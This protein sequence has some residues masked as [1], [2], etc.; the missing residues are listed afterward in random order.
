MTHRSSPAF[1]RLSI[2]TAV[3][4]YLLI[5]WGGV[6]RVSGSGLGCGTTNDWPLCHGQLLPP[7]QQDAVIEFTHRWL[8]AMST[9]LVAT[10]AVVSLVRWLRIRGDS[11]AAA[12]IE[13][14]RRTAQISG[15][16]V[17]LFMVQIVLGAITVKLQLPGYV[18]AVHLANAEFLLGSL[19][20]LAVRAHFEG[21]ERATT[22]SRSPAMAAVIAA[23]I[24]TYAL[25]ITGS[26]VV[27]SS[28]SDACSAWP[29]CGNG[30]QLS[31]TQLA[32][33]NLFHRFIAGLVIVAIGIAVMRVARVHHQ[34][35]GIR[36]VGVVATVLLLAQVIAGAVVVK[37][38]LPAAARGIHLALASA[39]WASVVLLAV[40]VRTAPLDEA[41]E[42][43]RGTTDTGSSLSPVQ[44]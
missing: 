1:R 22:P 29:L 33:V 34:C 37:A 42:H 25:V 31:T 13:Q 6:V 3:V 18:I 23:A 40:L 41:P 17:L 10:V 30:F 2:V 15:L 7:L 19:I 14:R 12:V 39:L 16:V 26:L 4:T 36:A 24:A 27:A 44:S 11:T 38:H 35:R 32:T 5:V 20:L 28:A 8:A 9:T 21:T 43:P